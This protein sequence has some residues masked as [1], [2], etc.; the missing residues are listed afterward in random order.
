MSTACPFLER[1]WDRIFSFVQ[2]T[3]PSL[4]CQILRPSFNLIIRSMIVILCYIYR[5]ILFRSFSFTSF[6][7]CASAVFVD[8]KFSTR[9]EVTC[10]PL[11]SHRHSKAKVPSSESTW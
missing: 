7:S 11:A 1:S 8:S 10:Y 5:V 6:A 3:L 4:V 2:Y 9:R